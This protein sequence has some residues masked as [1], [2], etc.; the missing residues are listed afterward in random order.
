MATM[1]GIHN[2]RPDI[3]PVAN[4]AVRIGWDEVGDLAEIGATRDAFKAAVAK[5]MPELDETSIPATAGTLYRFVHAMAEGDVVVCPNR[6]NRTLDIGTVTGPYEFHP[7]SQVYRH[8]RPVTWTRTGVPRTELSEAAQNEVSAATTLFAIT[9]AEEE[10]AHL[11][12]SP[13]PSVEDNYAWADFY[14][15]LTDAFLAYQSDRAALLEKVWQ[16][17]AASGRPQ[18]FKYLQSDHRTDGSYGPLRDVDPFTVLGSFNRGIRNEARALIARAFGEE[19]G[20]QP[21]YPDTFAGVPVVNNLNSWYVSW[22][23]ERGPHDVD[24]LWELCRAAI[25]YAAEPTEETRERLVTAFDACA[26]GGTRKLSM[27]IYWIRPHTFAA[28]DSTNTTFL[29][30]QFP[31]VAATLSLDA[32]IDGEQF[33]ANTEALVAWLADPGTPYNS[34]PE[35]SHAA[36]KYLFATTPDTAPDTLDGEAIFTPIASG[37]PVPELTGETYDVESIRDDGCFIP[38]AEL[39]PILE[40]LRSRKN[41]V[42]QGPPGTGKTWLARRLAWALCDERGSTRVQVV[43]FHPSLTYEDFVRGW[44]PGTMGLEL[45]DGPFLDMCGQAE[46]DPEHPYVLVI[47]EVNRGNPAQI[48]GELLTL[49]EADKRSPEQA[50]R[51]AYP[52]NKDERFAVPPNLHLI[53][54]MNVADRSLAMVDM[55]LRRRFA[56][57][58]LKP[59]FGDDWV[60]HLSGLGYD[61]DVLETCGNR[62]RSLNDTI[63]KDS[64]LG[65]QYCVGHSYFTPAVRLEQTGLDTADWWRRVVDTDVRPLL[66]EYWFDRPDVAEAEYRKLLGG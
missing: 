66:E 16:V 61:L 54:T 32:R 26:T 28:Y 12:A 64:A 39:E 27:G 19:F 10:I 63:T 43:Q 30:K 13:Q 4:G 52:R 41:I 59:A 6:A 15:R 57:I 31:E 53:G 46:A 36:W 9:T 48:L 22:E 40:R 35:L 45:A 3:N 49:I 1:W 5:H 14:P 29:K 62:V 56:F 55:A 34:F 60:Q 2:D 17:A 25:G 7:E 20:L 50:I 23:N 47:E 42:L 18:L 11:L 65:R 24:S 8:W 21:P 33:L 51:L 38:T 44:R 37:D 58:E